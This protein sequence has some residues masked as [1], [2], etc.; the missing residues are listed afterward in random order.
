MM[1]F[2]SGSPFLLF[3][4]SYFHIKH[5]LSPV[6]KEKNMILSG[7]VPVYEL[8]GSVGKGR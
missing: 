4:S 6:E 2:L 3:Y 5:V 1:S 8:K 7:S